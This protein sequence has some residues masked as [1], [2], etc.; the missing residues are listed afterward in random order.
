MAKGLKIEVI[1]AEAL[2]RGLEQLPVKVRGILEDEIAVGVQD[3][4]TD[5]VSY[6]PVDTG[7][8]RGSIRA[9]SEG[10]EGEVSTNVP[11]AGPM[12]FGTGGEVNI[13][14]G[15]EEIASQYKGRGV[16][17]VNI[18]PRPFMRPALEQNTP[19]IIKNING[20]IDDELNR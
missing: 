17:T 3:I 11:Y 6:A 18:T 7:L 19:K 14:P 5:A 12:E 8:L 13:Q 10:L 9:E 2:I 4:R 1:G 20:A 15:W 16:R